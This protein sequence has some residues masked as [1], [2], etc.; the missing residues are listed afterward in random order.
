MDYNREYEIWRK[1]TGSA[2][3]DEI[4]NNPDEIKERFYKNLDF[5]TA[6]MRGEVALGTN[7]MNI[8]TVA[9]ATQGLADF[10]ISQNLNARGV[11][12]GYDTRRGSI[13]FA[14]EVAK[15][16]VFNKIKVYLY[17]NVRPVPLVSFAIRE[18]NAAA[19]V[20]ITASH[21][22]K[23]YNGFKVYGEDGAQMSP[24]CTD[25]VVKYIKKITD[26]FSVKKADLSLSCLDDIKGKNN[27]AVDSCLTIIGKDI[28]NRYYD[29]IG[30]LSLSPD[31]VLRQSK[32]VKI[33]YTP[34]HGTGY[35]PV[36]DILKR[37]NI[38]C[39]L[40]KEQCEADTEFST[41]SVPNPE[42]T[43]T[44]KMGIDLA[45]RE[46]ASVV[47][48]TDPDC[49][50]MGVAIMDSVGNYFLLN[51]NQIGALLLDY[52]LKRHTELNSMP[53]NP[54]VI[55]TIVTTSLS[56]KIAENY[57]VASYDVLT[58]FKFIGEKILE[59]EGN[60]KHSFLFGYEESYGYLAGTHARD[61]DAVVSAMLF[62]EMVCYYKDKGMLVYDRLLE[63]FKNYGYYCDKSVSVTLSGIDGMEKMAKIMDKLHN[64]KIDII[65][66][67]KVEFI[68]DY[69]TR[70]TYY[71]DGSVQ[72]I[73]LPRS[74]VVYYGLS[75]SNW[76]CVRPS[77][78]EPKLKFY[79]SISHPL[80]MTE[81]TDKAN[82]LINAIKDIALN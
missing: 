72:P 5:G 12:I 59:W 79:V 53:A 19:G 69:D 32:S 68:S 71:Q 52:I 56:R 48:G 13:D 8:Y 76:I 35:I 26:F 42:N 39:I 24:D 66:D 65:G 16:L 64:T 50:R 34:I 15:V 45:M 10:I 57:S 29:A 9:V 67:Q 58:G 55:K 70:M 2:E 31:A 73:D 37:M 61:K 77:G 80:S 63:L 11:V 54:A 82:Y 43:E 38:P 3:L 75:S 47:I 81:A 21:N 33:V 51:G 14:L 17:E 23:E 7:R 22:P 4:I 46:G 41:V 20:I 74:N 27:Y 18:L 49:D 36:T 6:G 28:D 30:K 78:T 60:H 44:L 40:V 1:N 62:A 25:K